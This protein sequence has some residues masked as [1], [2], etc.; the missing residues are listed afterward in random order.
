MP[1]VLLRQVGLRWADGQEKVF[2]KEGST[3]C[4]KPLVT[5]N[6]V[7]NPPFN[8]HY[9]VVLVEHVGYTYPN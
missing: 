5:V 3:P 6:L 1:A 8:V 2:G 4:R 9:N 7:R